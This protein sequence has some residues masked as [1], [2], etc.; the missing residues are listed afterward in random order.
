[1]GVDVRL[2]L[3]VGIFSAS[4]FGQSPALKSSITSTTSINEFEKATYEETTSGESVR[5]CFCTPINKCKSYV[6][7]EDGGGLIDKR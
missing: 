3:V 5:E 2:I 1:M 6:P 7:R 4:T